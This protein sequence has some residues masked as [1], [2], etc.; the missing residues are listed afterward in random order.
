M[1]FLIPIVIFPLAGGY[2]DVVQFSKLINNIQKAKKIF[3]IFTQLENVM[4]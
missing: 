2:L 3:I 1:D 4:I